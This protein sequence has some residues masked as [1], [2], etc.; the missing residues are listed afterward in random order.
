MY[1]KKPLMIRNH[2]QKRT[3]TRTEKNIKFK[4]RII[5]GE[6]SLKLKQSW[7][8]KTITQHSINVY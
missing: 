7:S 6:Q 4:R 8:F 2:L 5:N 3:N 1:P